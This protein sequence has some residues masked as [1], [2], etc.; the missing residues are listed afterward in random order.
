MT[1]ALL[2]QH[3]DLPLCAEDHRLDNHQQAKDL[4]L[5]FNKYTPV[6]YILVC[7]NTTQY[8]IEVEAVPLKQ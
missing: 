1:P 5:F 8:N 2:E 7:I 6:L 4:P 3:N